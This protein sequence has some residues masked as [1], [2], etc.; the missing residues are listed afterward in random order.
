[1]L[2]I[3]EFARYAGVSVR[4]LRHY[5]AI[6][7]LAPSTTDPFTGYR[8]YSFDLLGR[9]N[10]VVALKELGFSLTEVKEIVD[11]AVDAQELRRL[12]ERRRSELAEQI[13]SDHAR[14]ADVERRLQLLDATTHVGSNAMH[15]DTGMNLEFTEKELPALELAQLT[16]TAS[17]Q[18]EIG[19]KIGPMFE[20]LVSR[21][22]E[23]GEQPSQ[24][25][26]A[27][28]VGD[29]EEMTFGAGFARPI[30]GT[31]TGCLEAAPRAVTTVYRGAMD[32]IGNAWQALGSHVAS[33]GLEFAGPG[34][35]VYHNTRGPEETWV[36]ELQQPVR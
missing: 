11:H 18:S 29:G 6:G 13:V 21:I 26:Y 12:L 34:R 7:L 14:L 8:S 28:Y 5:D 9:A 19:P 23:A 3:G 36:T 20:D 25:G 33:L 2:S 16:A 32:Q 24:P 1:M 22:V 31:E 30:K 4:M 17:E 35:E 10:A 15:Q 27:W